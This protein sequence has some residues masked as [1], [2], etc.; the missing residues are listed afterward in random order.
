MID[1]VILGD[2]TLKRQGC[3]YF[4]WVS[5]LM[6]NGFKSLGWILIDGKRAEV[7]VHYAA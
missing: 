3:S 4:Q 5:N 7:L 2:P 6:M 1:Y